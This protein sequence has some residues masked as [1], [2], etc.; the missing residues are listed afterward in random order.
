MVQRL[1]VARPVSRLLAR[2]LRPAD[3][4]LLRLTGGRLTLTTLLTGLP[5]VVLTTRGAR[6]SQPRSVPLVPLLDGEAVVLVA[7]AFGNKHHP[8]WYHNLRAHPRVTL[9]SDRRQAV[10]LAR[11]ATSEEWN[12]YWSMAVATYPGYAAYRARCGERAIPILVLTPDGPIPPP[13]V[14]PGKPSSGKPASG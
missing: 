6:S 13:V 9:S 4:W 14:D 11:P 2:G 5:V 10:Y 8:A 1:T 3:R 12:R 7:S